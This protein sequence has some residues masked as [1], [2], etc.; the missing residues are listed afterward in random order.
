[1]QITRFLAII[2]FFSLFTHLTHAQNRPILTAMP[3]LTI[4]PNAQSGGFGDIGVVAPPTFYASAPSQN[5][6]LLARNEAISGVFLGYSPWTRSQAIPNIHFLEGGNYYTFENGKHAIGTH[7]KY[8]SF[9][10]TGNNLAIPIPNLIF[11]GATD[12]SS[13]FSY[14]YA[15][16]EKLSIGAG[17]KY[18]FSDNT[19]ISTN[20]T[21]PSRAINAIAGDIGLLSHTQQELADGNLVRRSLGVSIVN[22]GPRV[23]HFPNLISPEYLPTTLKVGGIVGWT[24]HYK[25]GLSLEVDLATQMDKLLVP[26][27]GARANVNAFEGIFTSFADA[28]GGLSGELNEVQVMFGAIGRLNYEDYQVTFRTGFFLEHE[29]LGNRRYQTI[30]L[31][32]ARDG[33]QLA[34]SLILP[35]E[36]NNPLQNILRMTIA[37]NYKLG[38]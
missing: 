26:S 1:M 2:S 3:S 31:G 9:Q 6:A 28:P 23:T 20:I 37:Y 21:A 10:A 35:F 24:F 13:T 27:E 30:G 5:P 19:T 8:I 18:L 15:L 22:F 32:L 25:N 36:Q 29:D 16:T 14:A 7:F 4:S 17:I 34:S 33:L 12:F 38:K 11:L